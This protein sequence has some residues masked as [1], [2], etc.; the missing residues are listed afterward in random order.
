[1]NNLRRQFRNQELR[2]TKVD[3]SQAGVTQR[4]QIAN[5]A[6]SITGLGNR[7]LGQMLGQPPA[8]KS[9]E[10]QTGLPTG[11]RASIERLSGLALPDVKVHENSRRP[12]AL[13]ACAMTCGNEIFLG[14]GQEK[15]LAHEAWHVV[16]QRQGRVKSNLQVNNVRVS[17]DSSLERE[18][19]HMGARAAAGIIS[20][21]ETM[22][23][24]A[25]T[26]G[27]A[28]APVVQR[29]KVPATMG[30]NDFGQF[31]TTKFKEA[32]DRGVEIALEFKPNKPK[33]DAKKIAMSQSVKAIKEDGSAYATQPNMANRMV[34]AGKPGAGFTIDAPPSTNNPIY[35]DTK[36]LAANEDLKDTPM[37]GNNPANQPDL[38][39][40]TNY[41]LGYCYKD[42]PADPDKKTQAAAMYDMPQGRKKK[43]AGMEFETAAY[44]I[45]GADKG[46]YYGSV[47]WSYKVAGTDA[48]PKVTSADITDISEAS[49]G[50]P[51]AN[52]ME[53]AKLWNTGKTQGTLKVIADPAV[54][55]KMDGSTT[56][57]VAKGTVIKQLDTV[58]GG[59]THAMIKA[60][61]LTP[62]GAGTGHFF[63]INVPDVKDMGD[64]SANKQ[65]PIPTP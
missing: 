60:E 16:Q 43:G 65:L 47:K 63:Y 33:V 45:D 64:G 41:I 22:V 54:V 38:G 18:A 58:G 28:N 61:E 39:K 17:E 57:N 13:E 40:N 51:T 37:S 26:A 6:R 55:Y 4:K 50:T 46:K 9:R 20:S 5:A 42:K 15:H 21:K 35:F 59:P 44:A 10:R 36:N 53:A 14:P 23:T 1:M 12:A 48:A 30:Q 7:R 3:L 62:R 32:N 34:G 11:L 27:P 2:P 24:P 19:D 49:K 25:T 52:F 31:E 56:E 29:K 8:A